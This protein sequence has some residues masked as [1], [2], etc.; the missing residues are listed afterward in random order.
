MLPDEKLLTEM[1]RYNEEL[2]NAASCSRQ[3]AS[4]KLEGRTC[5]VIRKQAHRDRWAFRRNKGIDR[6]VLALGGEVK[7]R[8]D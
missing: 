7:G 2:A 4:P 8:G 1:G 6:R 5:Q 3:W